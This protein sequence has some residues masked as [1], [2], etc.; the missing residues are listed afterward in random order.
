MELLLN[1]L[2]LM[3]ALPAFLVWRSQHGAAPSSG[4]LHRLRWLVL[5]GCLM[6]LLFPVVSATDDLHPIRAEIE[7][8]SPSKRTVKQ[9]P[10]VKSP[11]WSNDGG[12]PLL[13]VSV[14]TLPA[15]NEARGLVSEC[16]IVLLQESPASTINDRAPPAA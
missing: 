8:S 15:D 14:A 10:S 13:L 1:L 12:R 6:A 5:L 4:K 11:A 9:S 16:R 3:L 2:W 7:E